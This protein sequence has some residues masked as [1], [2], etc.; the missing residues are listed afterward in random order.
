VLCPPTGGFGF[1]VRRSELRPPT[2]GFGLAACFHAI[3]SIFYQADSFVVPDLKVYS[4][5]VCY[6]FSISAI[7]KPVSFAISLSEAP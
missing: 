7:G 3:Q 2:G 5:L 6:N 4:G 1:R